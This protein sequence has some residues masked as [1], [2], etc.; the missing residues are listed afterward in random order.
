MVT[1]LITMHS[2][3]KNCNSNP[4]IIWGVELGRMKSNGN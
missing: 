2:L 3:A 1:D 4:T